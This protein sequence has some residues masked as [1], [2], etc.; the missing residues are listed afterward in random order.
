M[1]LDCSTDTFSD[2]IH[3]LT[4]NTIYLKEDTL[5]TRNKRKTSDAQIRAIRNYEAKNIEQKRYNS[6]KSAAKNFILKT[7][8]DEDLDLVREW[9]QLREDHGLQE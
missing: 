8:T 1:D 3:Y 9:L 2:C 7:A 6:K 5:V 4:Y